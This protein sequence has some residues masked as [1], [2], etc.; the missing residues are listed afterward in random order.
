[1]PDQTGSFSTIVSRCAERHN[2]VAVAFVTR[3][4][5]LEPTLVELDFGSARGSP[6]GTSLSGQKQ[7]LIERAKGVA[8]QWSGS[9]NVSNLLV[10]E[11]TSSFSNRLKVASLEGRGRGFKSLAR[12]KFLSAAQPLLS[13]A[14]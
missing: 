6:L 4:G 8:Q 1:M 7:Q 13:S 11:R 2:V 12:S 3:L 5:N 10:S 14:R 9:P